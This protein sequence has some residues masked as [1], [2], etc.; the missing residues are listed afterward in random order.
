MKVLPIAI[1]CGL[2]CGTLGTLSAV[3]TVLCI[4]RGDFLTAAVT[5]GIAAFCFGFIIPFFKVVPGNIAPRAKFD[6]EGTT[7]R[8]DGGI[9]IPIQIS[10]F[11]LVL[12]CA[13]FVIFAPL[14]KVDIPVPPSMRY[15]IPFTS[16]VVVLMGVPLV[17]RNLRRGSTKYL[18]VTPNGY[19]LAQGWGSA[20]GDW[21]QVQDVSDEAPGQKAPTPGAV[22]FVMSDDSSHTVAAVESHR[23]VWRCDSWFGSTGSTRTAAANSPTAEPSSGL[24]RSVSTHLRS[25]RACARCT[26]MTACRCADTHA[27][28]SGLGCQRHRS[29]GCVAEERQRLLEIQLHR[30][31]VV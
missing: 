23:M 25:R 14:G 20:S 21:E 7:F 26:Q 13:L 1:L 24:P 29:L 3:W 27:R 30:G 28:R 12:A 10:V 19:E 9:D 18:R 2:F 6:D 31:S 17:W 4:G 16:G 8:P 15:S 22:V 5:L 11:G